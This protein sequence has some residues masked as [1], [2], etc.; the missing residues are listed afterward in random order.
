MSVPEEDSSLSSLLTSQSKLLENWVQLFLFPLIKAAAGHKESMHES[1]LIGKKNL[2]FSVHQSPFS[3]L[4]NLTP[5]KTAKQCHPKVDT[6]NARPKPKQGEV[7][8]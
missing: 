2:F 3:A 5:Y 1:N 6:L 7:L 4:P 8:L